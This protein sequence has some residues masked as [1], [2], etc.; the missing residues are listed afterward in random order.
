MAARAHTFP[1]GLFAPNLQLYFCLSPAHRTC[2]VVHMASPSLG[3]S[4]AFMRSQCW[5]SGSMTDR[6]VERTE[7]PFYVPPPPSI[8]FEIF[9]QKL[10]EPFTPH[11]TLDPK[12]KHSVDA[13]AKKNKNKK[14]T[15]NRSVEEGWNESKYLWAKYT[16]LYL[17]CLWWSDWKW[18]M[19]LESV[20]IQLQFSSMKRS[21]ESENATSCW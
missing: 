3:P 10:L 16:Q 15:V 9:I 20:S 21:K 13:S 12:E 6:L 8:P 2:P 1:F 19:W 11:Q 18:V 14:Y 17:L 5:A 7:G 4:L